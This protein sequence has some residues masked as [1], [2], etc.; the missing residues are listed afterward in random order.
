MS[1]IK[2]RYAHLE[3]TVITEITVVTVVVDDRQK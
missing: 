2:D 3:I 1:I